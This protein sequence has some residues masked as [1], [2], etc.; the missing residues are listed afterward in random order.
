MWGKNENVVST[1]YNS[2][3]R[4]KILIKMF[5]RPR[6]IDR[7]KKLKRATFTVKRKRNKI[8]KRGLEVPHYKKRRIDV[9]IWKA[10]KCLV[11][12]IQGEKKSSYI[13]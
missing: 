5:T 8:R 7:G 10:T 3:S 11:F 2:K 12:K 13:T 1:C 9:G 4:K 6:I